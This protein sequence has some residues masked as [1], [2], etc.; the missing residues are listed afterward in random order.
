MKKQTKFILTFLL[1]TLLI[2]PVFAITK[3]ATT[4]DGTIYVL[5]DD[6]TYEE[7]KQK[8]YEI[9][10]G[11][12]AINYNNL[13]FLNKK[14]KNISLTALGNYIPSSSPYSLGSYTTGE[15]FLL[16]MTTNSNVFNTPRHEIPDLKLSD[17]SII[18]SNNER[19]QLSSS[20]SAIG[21]YTKKQSPK[22]LT[23]SVLF[24]IPKDLKPIN[25]IFKDK[26][27]NTLINFG[28]YK[29]L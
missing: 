21:W 14:W 20:S 15:Y 23:Y 6:K 7:F 3:L 12:E 22:N 2:S 10:E 18:K 24:E 25:L 17:G 11:Y 5:N 4:E 29:N 13:E 26:D 8:I 16:Q 9:E 19:I 1:L 27:T 28:K